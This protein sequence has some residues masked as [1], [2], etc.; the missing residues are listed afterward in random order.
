MR[1]EKKNHSPNESFVIFPFQFFLR[2]LYPFCAVLVTA[3]IFTVACLRTIVSFA[4][5][6][7]RSIDRRPDEEQSTCVFK[8][9][10]S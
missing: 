4:S 5:S 8:H 10:D 3:Y 6:L 2:V 1:E 9:L 7:H